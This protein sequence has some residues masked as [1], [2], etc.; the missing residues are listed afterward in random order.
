MLKIY[1][2]LDLFKWWLRNAMKTS[3]CLNLL[4]VFKL[5][6]VMK[7]KKYIYIVSKLRQKSH[8]ETEWLSSAKLAQWHHLLTY[9]ISMQSLGSCEESATCHIE[10]SK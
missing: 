6:L 10:Y 9:L 8:S 2:E 1:N 5:F 3:V 4:A 7:M